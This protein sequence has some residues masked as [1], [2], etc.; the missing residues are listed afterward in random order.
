MGK[1]PIKPPSKASNRN[2]GIG[3]NG[4]EGKGSNGANVTL[5]A[6][7]RYLIS[8][9]LKVVCIS[10]SETQCIIATS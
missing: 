4:G 1:A 9:Y 7:I 10:V 5:L 6:T 8:T 3:H 2:C